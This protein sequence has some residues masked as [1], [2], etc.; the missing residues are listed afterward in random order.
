LWTGHNPAESNAVIYTAAPNVAIWQ[1]VCALCCSLT[2]TRLSSPH[3]V[4]TLP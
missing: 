2:I 3:P 1:V 4:A